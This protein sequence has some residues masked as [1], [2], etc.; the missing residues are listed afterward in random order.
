MNFEVVEEYIASVGD[1]CIITADKIVLDPTDE[2]AYTV[3]AHAA[4]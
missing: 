3:I 4:T 2:E 1:R